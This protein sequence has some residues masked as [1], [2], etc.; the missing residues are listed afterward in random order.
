MVDET[1]S[2][3]LSVK[4]QGLLTPVSLQGA[5]TEQDSYGGGHESY[6]SHTHTQKK[7]K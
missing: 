4:Y 3:L 7:V 1:C 5:V 6:N 2:Y